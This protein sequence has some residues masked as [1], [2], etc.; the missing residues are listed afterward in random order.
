MEAKELREK[1]DHILYLFNTNKIG[2]TEARERFLVIIEEA[3]PEL[4]RKVGYVKLAEDQSL[5]DNVYQV[6]LKQFLTANGWRRVEE[7]HES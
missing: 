1:I 5:S 6:P 2:Y 4:A 3:L 7:K